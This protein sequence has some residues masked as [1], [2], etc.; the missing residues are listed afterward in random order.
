MARL[1]KGNSQLEEVEKNKTN[2]KMAFFM[3]IKIN[4]NFCISR[5]YK[6]ENFNFPYSHPRDKHYEHPDILFYAYFREAC[7]FLFGITP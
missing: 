1:S 7:I 4:T 5:T 6:E 3:I 2:N